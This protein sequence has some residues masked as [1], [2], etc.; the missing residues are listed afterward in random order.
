MKLIRKNSINAGDLK[1]RLTLL[2]PTV[3][4]DG[5]G[6]SSTVYVSEFTVWCKATPHHNTRALDEAQVIYYDAFRFTIRTSELNLN[7]TWKIRFNG[8]EYTIHTIDDIENRYQYLE[9]IAY[10]KKL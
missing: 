10:S 3:L 4:P 6:G 9:I 7:G 5:R 1:D 8:R 2:M